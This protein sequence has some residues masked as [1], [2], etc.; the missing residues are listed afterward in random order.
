MRINHDII[1][2]FHWWRI[3][4]SS[5]CPSLIGGESCHH[6]SIWVSLVENHDIISVYESHWWRIMSSSECLIFIGGGSWHHH[7]SVWSSLVE[8]RDIIR[9]SEFHWWRIKI[10]SE[11][12]IECYWERESGLLD[13]NK[14]YWVTVPENIDTLISPVRWPSR[15]WIAKTRCC[16]TSSYP[17]QPEGS[18]RIIPS[19]PRKP[20][21]TQFRP[22]TRRCQFQHQENSPYSLAAERKITFFYSLNKGKVIQNEF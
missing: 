21:M 22:R 16:C 2:E 11:W 13:M 15:V 10:L 6:Q 8:N 18:R 7:Q 3:I 1:S 17:W 20:S 12:P 19:P 9:V 14:S 5:E 4:T